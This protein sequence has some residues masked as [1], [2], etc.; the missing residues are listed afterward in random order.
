MLY[1][2]VFFLAENLAL[3]SLSTSLE[4]RTLI[5]SGNLVFIAF[6][7]FSESIFEEVLKFA[8]CDSAC[9]PASVLPDAVTLIFSLH[10]K[11]M[12]S[13]IFFCIVI[14]FFFFCHPE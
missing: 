4:E 10:I 12:A 9:T 8:I 11:L 1:I 7:N 6:A 5:S 3:K 2:Y 13:S 14:A